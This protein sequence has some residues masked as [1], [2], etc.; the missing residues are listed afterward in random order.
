MYALSHFFVTT[1]YTT[2]KEESSATSGE[3]VATTIGGNSCSALPDTPFS[4]IGSVVIH[5]SLLKRG[6]VLTHDPAMIGIMVTMR[7][8][9]YVDHTIR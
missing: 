9:G 6:G 4:A 2:I 8:P 3:D 1:Q 5:S 7:A